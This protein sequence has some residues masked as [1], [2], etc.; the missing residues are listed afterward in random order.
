MDPDKRYE[1]LKGIFSAAVRSVDPEQL[2]CDR[3][4][5]KGNRLTVSSD[6]EY[7]ELDL[8]EFDRVLV[9][10]AGKATAKM[11][12]AVEAILGD[13]ISEG[14]ISVKYGHTE[15]LKAVSL[16][17]AG[18][19]VPD[20]N[21]M[22]AA[23]GI[24]ELARK[25]DER[26]LVLNLISGGGSALLAGPLSVVIGGEPLALTIDDL[27]Q[28]TGV[29]LG[30]GATIEEM[31][32]IRKHLS[33]IKG[34]R[35]AEQCYPA[36]QINLLLSD[37]IGDRLDTIASGL[38]SPDETTFA[39]ALAILYKYDIWNRMPEKVVRILQA[40]AHG[41]LPETPKGDSRVFERVKNLI[42]GNNH[43]AVQAALREAGRRG[44][45]GVALSSRISGEAREAA[46]VFA[47]IVKD[48]QRYGRLAQ[49]PACIL[50]GGETT[51]TLHGLGRGGR[52]QEFALSFLIELREY[53]TEEDC[54]ITL[55]AASTDGNDGPTD[56][57]GAFAAT[58]VLHA[59][60][61]GS[62]D[63]VAFLKNNDSYTF[64]EKTDFLLKTGPT[65]TNVCDLQ[66]ALIT[67]AQSRSSM[68]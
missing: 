67:A 22:R 21:S 13:R 2:I 10:G 23:A 48:V 40:G 6:L 32:C 39:D 4:R 51:V 43:V 34:G 11:A 47:G 28:S 68:P 8:G 60:A 24:T 19:P 42:I 54:G 66:I 44:Y 16:I 26:T 56:A 5:L 1:D 38:T 14:L 65:N 15:E 50:W 30:S 27:Q 52:N 55:L 53:G 63:P 46:K 20:A 35:L 25:A 45:H 18:H 9:L 31:N 3:M 49:I 7:V 33:S 58:G 61:E 36:V 59:A 37:V 64:F 29:L 57:A 17:E 41:M 62:L 12:K